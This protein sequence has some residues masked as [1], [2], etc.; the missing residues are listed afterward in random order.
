MRTNWISPKEL[1]GLRNAWMCPLSQIVYDYDGVGSFSAWHEELAFY[2]LKDMEKLSNYFE[3]FNF[4]H[5]N[6][7]NSPFIS[8]ATEYLELKGWV[9]LHGWSGSIPEWI[10]DSD[11]RLTKAQENRILDWCIENNRK[12]DNCFDRP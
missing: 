4:I 9:R 1:K 12:Y 8:S 11:T 2:I 6:K 10:L 7:Y 5:N 3:A